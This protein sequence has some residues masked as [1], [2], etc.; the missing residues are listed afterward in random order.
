MKVENINNGKV[1]LETCDSVAIIT[2]SRPEALNALTW[3]MYEQL[4][5]HLDNLQ[6]DSS[7]RVVIIRGDKNKSLAVGTDINQFQ[8]FTGEDGVNYEKRIDKIMT[9][10][11]EFPKPTIAAVN[12]FAVGGG[13]LIATSCDL[14]YATPNSRFGA[15]MARTLGNCLSL[16]NYRRLSE[17]VGAMRTKELL[18][19][20]RLIP[21]DEA[22]SIGFLTEIF[23]EERFFN[24]VMEVATKISNHAPLT[25]KATKESFKT[26]SH[27][28]FEKIIFNVYDSKDFAEGV[29][30]YIEKRKPNWT[31]E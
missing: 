28:K 18:Y 12:G 23:E 13:M 20:A 22:L 11:E 5:K 8:G 30:A 29:N 4:D 2:L 16:D 6:N 26:A 21:A 27:D 25:I 1:L 24:N 14:R 15:P 9:K 19:T 7:I 10:L 31:G 17:A 3:E